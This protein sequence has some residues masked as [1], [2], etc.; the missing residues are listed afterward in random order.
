MSELLFAI[1]EHRPILKFATLV[2]AGRRCSGS[3]TLET[4]LAFSTGANKEPLLGFTLQPM[5][6]FVEDPPGFF[7]TANTCTMT[8]ALPFSMGTQQPNAKTLFEKF[9]EAFISDYFGRH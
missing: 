8:L 2:S 7:P 3:I 4:L 9:D 6:V 1:C 5:I